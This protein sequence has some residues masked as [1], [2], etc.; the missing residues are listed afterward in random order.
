[1]VAGRVIRET[2]EEAGCALLRGLRQRHYIAQLKGIS[3]AV[4]K[5]IELIP[6]KNDGFPRIR[7]HD[8]SSRG[9]AFFAG[10][11]ETPMDT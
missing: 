5:M 7:R 10:M 4:S 1:M 9:F 3:A 8:C 2:Q 11:S 6:E